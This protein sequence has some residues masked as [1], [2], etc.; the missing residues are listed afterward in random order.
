VRQLGV[1]VFPALVGAAV[2]VLLSEKQYQT[3]KR[4]LPR[5]VAG[6]MICALVVFAYFPFAQS[7]HKIRPEFTQ[8]L[9][10]VLR[11][12]M[13]NGAFYLGMFFLY[14]T[15]CLLPL[16]PRPSYSPSDWKK[17]LLFAVPTAALCIIGIMVAEGRGRPAMT[18]AVHASFPFLNN[19]IY[20]MGVGPITLSDVYI[21]NLPHPQWPAVLAQLFQW[22]LVVLTIL[23]GS[24][25]WK[26]GPFFATRSSLGKPMRE[27]AVF[28]LIFVVL[29]LAVVIQCF[30][31]AV[32][33][34]YF[35]NCL[36]VLSIPLAILQQTEEAR[37]HH[38]GAFGKG[39]RVFSA[40]WLL[41]L[42]LFA[43]LGI[44]DYFRWNEVRWGLYRGLRASGIPATVIQAGYEV[45]GWE[46][47]DSFLSG[48]APRGCIGDCSCRVFGWWSLD[49]SYRV[50]MNVLDDYVLIKA[51]KPAYLL[52]DGP[53]VFVS[54]RR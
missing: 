47:Y 8:P 53:P 10:Q 41:A 18:S 46:N 23:G 17:T 19:I 51:V 4:S 39:Q 50:G 21:Y 42:I 12:D 1:L 13:A 30:K 52:A 15:F 3:L 29:T 43:T 25:L 48:E 38:R 27:I 14:A 26:L 32:F 11:P 28:S 24:T 7:A 9:S 22:L 33:D 6:G 45:N 2:V 44:H 16:L 35:L 40:A 31:W 54:K 49:D 34:R 37:G 20:N 5:F 36:V